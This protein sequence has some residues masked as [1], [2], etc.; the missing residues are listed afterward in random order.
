MRIM[1]CYSER[2]YD[3]MYSYIKYTLSGSLK[4]GG[5]IVLTV[6]TVKLYT[7]QFWKFTPQTFEI[8]SN[9]QLIRP[10]MSMRCY[11]FKIV[12]VLWTE[13]SITTELPYNMVD[14]ISKFISGYI[15]T[16][17]DIIHIRYIRLWTRLYNSSIIAL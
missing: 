9:F 10:K 8:Y 11:N 3:Y 1:R 13:N 7:F 2:T 6:D 14:I 5:C 17:Y 12:I 15:F 4:V 16:E